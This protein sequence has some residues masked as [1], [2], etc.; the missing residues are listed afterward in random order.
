MRIPRN[1]FIFTCILKSKLLEESVKRDISKTYIFQNKI[2]QNWEI[3]NLKK[4]V[5]SSLT[6]T[7]KVKSATTKDSDKPSKGKDSSNSFA[8]KEIIIVVNSLICVH[9][10]KV[11]EKKTSS[12]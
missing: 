4:I 8:F 5:D 9:A 6:E 2:F 1:L 7:K 11:K 12:Y 10:K 3:T